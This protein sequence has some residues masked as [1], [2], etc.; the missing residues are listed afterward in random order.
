ML[1]HVLDHE[2]T[3]NRFRFTSRSR[4]I[5]VLKVTF[6]IMIIG[7]TADFASGQFEQSGSGNS[8]PD[9]PGL[10]FTPSQEYRKVTK[11]GERSYELYAPKAP[12]NPA[13]G[14]RQPYIYSNSRGTF[15]IPDFSSVN[16]GSAKYR[17]SDGTSHNDKLTYI[18]HGHVTEK[19]GHFIAHGTRVS[20][21][22]FRAEDSKG[23]HFFLYF[24]TE[25]IINAPQGKRYPMYYSWGAPGPAQTY[26]FLSTSG[27]TRQ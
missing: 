27:T 3:T 21:W 22:A 7:F 12:S 1:T 6:L 4:G 25:P 20:V 24:G 19:E 26:R 11:T 10:H 14:P 5:A 16:G 17:W 13:G 18:S 9:G 2:K 8:Q 23:N 15:K